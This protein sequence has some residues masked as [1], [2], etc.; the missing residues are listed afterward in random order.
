MAKRCVL[1]GAQYTPASAEE[2]AYLDLLLRTAD[3][4]GT[5]SVT[6]G[7]AVRF[8]GRAGLLREALRSVS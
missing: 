1:L 8:F 6:G 5:G 4:S 7:D 2:R 3:S